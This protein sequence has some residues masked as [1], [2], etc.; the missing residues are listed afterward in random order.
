MIKKET[1]NL[2]KEGNSVSLSY[3][4]Y[5]WYIMDVNDHYGQNDIKFYVHKKDIQ[6]LSEFFRSFIQDSVDKCR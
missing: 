1:Y 3:I 6:G 2:S 5:D 4:D